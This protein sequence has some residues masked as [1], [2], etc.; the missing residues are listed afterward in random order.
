[1]GGGHLW[2]STVF[3]HRCG[4]RGAR[5]D[6]RP[7]AVV[8]KGKEKDWSFKMKDTLAANARGVKVLQGY[9]VVVPPGARDL[10]EL[11]K[12]PTEDELRDIVEAAGGHFFKALPS[13][14]KAGD[15]W[16][17]G[18]I[19]IACKELLSDSS[20]AGLGRAASKCQAGLAKLSKKTLAAVLEPAD[21]YSAIFSKTFKPKAASLKLPKHLKHII[22]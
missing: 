11:L 21:L 5:V 3:D 4:E 18:L 9:A 2:S 8:D 14:D 10:P 19:A 20:K 7:Y 17:K 6:E 16:P 15:A 1:M 13:S 12:L 22:I